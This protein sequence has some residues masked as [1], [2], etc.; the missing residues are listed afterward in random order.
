MF[1]ISGKY[2]IEFKPDEFC[3]EIKSLE[4]NRIA[5]LLNL[6]VPKVIRLLLQHKHL[7]VSY[8]DI[9]TFCNLKRSNQVFRLAYTNHLN[10]TQDSTFEYLNQYLVIDIEGQTAKFYDYEHKPDASEIPH[11]PVVITN[12]EDSELKATEHV[13]VLITTRITIND[14]LNRQLTMK[15]TP[16][17]GYLLGINDNNIANPD[18]PYYVYGKATGLNT[19]LRQLHFVGTTSGSGSVEIEVD[20]G[21]GQEDSTPSTTIN[22]N[23][24]AGVT[25]SVPELNVPDSVSV[26]LHK[27]T[28]ITP[29]ITVSDA[30]DKLLSL[31]IYPYQ[32]EVYGW[33]SFGGYIGYG[34]SRVSNGR[35]EIINADIEKLY[36]RAL[37]NNAQLGLE[38]IC[39]RTVIRDYLVFT[40]TDEPEEPEESTVPELT[41]NNIS[42]NI[43]ADVA[44]GASFST[45]GVTEPVTVTITPTNCNIKNY[46]GETINAGTPKT[47]TG[48]VSAINAKLASAQVNITSASGSVAFSW[49]DGSKTKNITVT[50]TEMASVVPTLTVSNLRGATSDQVPLGAT[51]STEGVTAE[52]SVSIT[53]TG[54]NLSGLSGVKAGSG[55]TLTGSIADINAALAKT[56]V[57][58]GSGDGS[59]KFSWNGGKSTKSITVTMTLPVPVD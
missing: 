53:P 54:C 59:I 22:I 6:T 13:P 3:Y 37:K 19:T 24:E 9:A 14:P 26:P 40:V 39:G 47:D 29:A 57:V 7:Q 51:F 17:N 38:L 2:S 11:V 44:L 55:A 31:R 30:D 16:T 48:E 52:Q 58:V 25:V 4:D 50:G 34:Q 56:K 10:K 18:T 36:V 5:S 21:E 46:G 42:G 12:T 33:K 32:C 35:P 20:D 1:G 8:R 49:E 43:G 15:L 28:L 27:D 23:I 45:E 41:V